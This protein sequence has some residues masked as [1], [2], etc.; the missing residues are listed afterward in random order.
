MSGCTG[1]SVVIKGSQARK[2]QRLLERS[3]TLDVVIRSSRCVILS[4]WQLYFE[5]SVVHHPAPL[6]LFGEDVAVQFRQLRVV[7]RTGARTP[8]S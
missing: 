2:G 4:L 1:T 8:N 6:A 7:T 5:V 3:T